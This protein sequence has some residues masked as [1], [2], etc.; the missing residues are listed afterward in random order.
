MGSTKAGHLL[1]HTEVLVNTFH[2]H[3]KCCRAAA[4]A[5]REELR[6]RDGSVELPHIQTFHHQTGKYRIED[7]DHEG[8]SESHRKTV[9]SQPL[10]DTDDGRGVIAR[11]LRDDTRQ[12]RKDEIGRGLHHNVYHL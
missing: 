5:E 2:G 12:Q 4:G 10:E 11:H 8:Q 6:G 1:A 9:P 3:R 7:E